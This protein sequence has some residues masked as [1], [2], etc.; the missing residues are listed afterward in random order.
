M[1]GCNIVCG[2]QP[3]GSPLLLQHKQHKCCAPESCSLLDAA[4]AATWCPRDRLEELDPN[5]FETRAAELLH[6][7]GFS[8]IMMAR[9]TKDMS[10]A[11]TALGVEGFGV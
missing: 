8:R 1:Q 3:P 2:R 6:G 9:K 5:T 11:W 4:A 7:L 10:G